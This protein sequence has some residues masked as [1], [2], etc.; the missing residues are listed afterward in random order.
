MLAAMRL[1]SQIMS[2]TL[3]TAFACAS[4]LVVAAQS[5][6]AVE[7]LVEQGQEALAAGRFDAAE[8]AF[9]KLSK[10]E[11]TVAEVH[12]NLGAIYFQEG[13]YDAAAE[14][15]RRA[16]KLKPTLTKAKTLLAISLSES[17]HTADALPGLEAGFHAGDAQARRMCGMQL[18]R[19]Y[20]A[21]HRDADA[22]T[23]ALALNKLY[24][25]D[26]EILYQTGRIYGNYTYLTMERLRDKAPNSVWM[27][28]AAAEA[29]ESEKNYDAALRSFEAV[30][31]LEPHRP[32]VHY[33]MGRVY[34]AR[35]EG[36][37]IEADRIAAEEQFR[38][39]LVN[40]PENGNALY[41]LAQIHA[42]VGKQEEAREEFKTL[43]ARRPDFE[44]ARVGYAGVLIE[45]Q[46]ADLAVTQLR[47]AAELD[48]N[49]EVA[50]YRLAR[51]LREAGDTASYKKAM[52]E[53][54]R[55]HAAESGRLA[56]A[57]ILAPVGEVTP[58]HLDTNAQP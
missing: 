24:P 13:K 38:A 37:R 6:E 10:L 14:S 43:V 20:T 41:E 16:L 23:T 34:L 31:R 1:L 54:Q 47:R 25:E 46:K 45:Q 55:V 21:L 8:V 7:Q 35:Y 27:L 22:V 50:W 18:M 52:A 12:A 49:D 26:A 33:R 56:R 58:Q 48:P 44:Q 17:G 29:Q 5:S 4:S 2:L 53:F 28:Q 3:V 30:L 15:L 39:E 57:G 42:D 32:G 19:A 9:V 40:D 11:P 36:T 51:A